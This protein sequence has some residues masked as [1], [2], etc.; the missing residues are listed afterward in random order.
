MFNSA[1]FGR[2]FKMCPIFKGNRL[3]SSEYFILLQAWFYVSKTEVNDY[4]HQ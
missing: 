2:A 3:A 4:F 1:I